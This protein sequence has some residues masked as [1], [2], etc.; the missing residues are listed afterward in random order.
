[1]SLRTGKGKREG[2]K[3]E[4]Q[5]QD[6]FNLFS[7]L[8]VV[9]LFVLSLDDCGG[10]ENE[11]RG[12]GRKERRL[13][14][15]TGEDCI[16]SLFLSILCFRTVT[17]A[18]CEEGK[19]GCEQA[20]SEKD[21]KGRRE[22]WARGLPVYPLADSGSGVCTAEPS[23]HQPLWQG[24]SQE[25]KAEILSQFLGK[26]IVTGQAMRRLPAWTKE[27]ELYPQAAHLERHQKLQLQQ[28]TQAELKRRWFLLQRELK[29]LRE[30]IDR[31]PGRTMRWNLYC[32]HLQ[33]GALLLWFFSRACLCMQ[34]VTFVAKPSAGG[35][36]GRFCWRVKTAF[37]GTTQSLIFVW[38]TVK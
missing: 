26:N 4:R 2:R 18:R 31:V 25:K 36:G 1:M 37:Y 24:V 11:C 28:R 29:G 33:V 17:E 7:E 30:E 13:F 10:C 14:F 15:C 5:I 3:R 8:L 12:E 34:C 6:G 38:F 27:G 9:V 35:R 19:E 22:T 32:D 21:A 20:P 23:R 16:R